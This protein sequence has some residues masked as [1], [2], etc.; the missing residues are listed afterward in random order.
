M[1]TPELFR[2]ISGMTQDQMRSWHKK[3]LSYLHPSDTAEK[4]L[5]IDREAL[6]LEARI[7]ELEFFRRCIAS[8]VGEKSDTA[9]KLLMR[10]APIGTE[11]I[12]SAA[13]WQSWFTE[14]EPYLFFS[15]QADYRWYIDPLAKKRRIPS[16]QLR[17]PARASRP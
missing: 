7:G 1:L 10:Y 3:N 4:R 15:D 12:H 8:L 13:D 14:N 5:E 17:G 9:R 2:K 6:A 11:N 16:A